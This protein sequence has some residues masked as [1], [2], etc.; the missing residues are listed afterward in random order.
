[1]L[2]ITASVIFSSSHLSCKTNIKGM[3]HAITCIL[4]ILLLSGYEY[5]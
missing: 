2:D 4:L 5:E 3:S 1:M